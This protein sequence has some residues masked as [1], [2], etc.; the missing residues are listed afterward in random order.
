MITFSRFPSFCHQIIASKP[1]ARRGR[2]PRA[3][4][5][6]RGAA[7]GAAAGGARARYS[8]SAP[9]SKGARAPAQPAAPAI[10]SSKIIISNLPADVN[11]AAIR[12]L[13]QSTVGPT[14]S[15]LMAYTATG[16][17]TGVS[18]VIFR[19]KGDAQK[20]H[21]KCMFGVGRADKQTT[22]G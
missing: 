11:E 20:A 19:N 17:S 13:M 22:T 16:K 6:G 2:G 7:E 18:T 5:A 12:D 9:S 8:G 3:A 21:A 14:K 10:E 15:V 4:G 1:R